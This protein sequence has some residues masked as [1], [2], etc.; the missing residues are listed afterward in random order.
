LFKKKKDDKEND[1]ENDNVNNAT[2]EDHYIGINNGDLELE[3]NSI[4]KD[5]IID[6][7]YKKKNDI[8][9]LYYQSKSPYKV[10]SYRGYKEEYE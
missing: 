10:Y 6:T 5:P 3:F 1:N 9:D 4:Y 7:Q 8:I 2:I